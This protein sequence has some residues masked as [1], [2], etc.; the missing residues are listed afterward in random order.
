M[1]RRVQLAATAAGLRHRRPRAPRRGR[2]PARPPPAGRRREPAGPPRG[3]RAAR[4]E[5]AGVAQP[6]AEVAVP[7]V[8][9]SAVDLP[10]RPGHVATT[11]R[12]AASYAATTTVAYPNLMF[13]FLPIAVRYDGSAPA[14]ARPVARSARPRI[15]GPRRADVLRRS[16]L[17]ADHLAGRSGQAGAALQ[18]PVDT[19]RPPRSGSRRSTSPATSSVSRRSPSS[20]PARC[21]QAGRA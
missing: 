9:R 10:Q 7:P 17:G 3:L 19:E 14:P 4:G 21:R 15:P 1:R 20:M 16:R 6:A 8:G 13:H 12:P 11:S 18:L 5:S 2:R